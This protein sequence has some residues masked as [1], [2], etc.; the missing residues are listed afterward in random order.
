MDH[1]IQEV[2]EFVRDNDVKFIR[3]A[4]CDLFGTQKNIS[5]MPD[6]LERAFREGISFD[7]SNIRGFCGVEKSELFLIPDAATLSVL[8]WRPQQGRV[9]RFYC[10]IKNP[11]GTPYV[12]D[13]RHILKSA[14]KRCETM[15]YL[16]KAGTECEFYL[17]KTDEDGNPVFQTHDEAGYFDIAPLDKGENVRREICLCLEEMGIT[18][19]SS[20]HESGP[21]QNE[22]DFKYCDL[23]GT[24][25]NLLTFKSVVKAIAA[26]NGLYASFM[27]KPISFESGSGLHINLSLSQNGKNIFLSGEQHNPVAES[28]MAGIMEHAA[29][30]TA[31]LNPIQNSYERFGSFEA[32]KYVSW[33]HQNRSQLVRIPAQAGEKARMELRSPDPSLNPY[34]AFAILLHAGLDGIEQSAALTEAVDVN[35]FTADKTIINKLTALPGSL[36][37]AIRIA[38]SS[39]FIRKTLNPALLEKYFLIK[40]EEVLAFDKTANKEVFYKQIYFKLI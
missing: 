40:K 30:M 35:L 24:A 4:F 8:P 38:S 10:S 18:P 7:G 27:P 33:S 9:V 6:Q 25:D 32:P 15:G 5:I 23:L 22:I 34:L 1:T 21:G 12:C 37:E 14:I 3:L 17:F 31:F 19:E 16:P 26:R 20:H 39:S 28:F 36:E 2:L 13:T 29:E 11:D